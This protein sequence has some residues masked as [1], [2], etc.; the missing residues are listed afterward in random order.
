MI[1][2]YDCGEICGGNLNFTCLGVGYGQHGCWCAAPGQQKVLSCS[3]LES[4]L[5]DCETAPDNF[6]SDKC[7]TRTT[8]STVRM[9]GALVHCA[10]DSCHEICIEA[11]ELCTTCIRSGIDDGAGPCGLERSVCDADQ[12]DEPGP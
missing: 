3:E 12:N 5:R 4:C 1:T 9:F 2:L 6:C 11:P 8:G 7:F 10:H